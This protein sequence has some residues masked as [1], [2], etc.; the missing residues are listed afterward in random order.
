ML[1]EFSATNTT[2][3]HGNPT[4][5][6][7][8]ATGLSITWQDG[9]LGRGR[10]R[11]QPNGAFVETVIAAAVQRLT[12]YQETSEGKFACPE[13]D[14]AIAELGSALACLKLRTNERESRGVEGTHKP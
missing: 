6:T 12:F 8:E 3:T 10:S 9:P 14:G 11:K 1:Q 5:G 4:G 2:D 13:N 7:V